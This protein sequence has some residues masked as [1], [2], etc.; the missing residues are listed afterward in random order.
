M[1]W[2]SEF[3]ITGSLTVCGSA[4]ATSV[5]VVQNLSVFC[6]KTAALVSGM[7]SV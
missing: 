2:F 7:V 1:A 5:S 3:I 6:R 4:T